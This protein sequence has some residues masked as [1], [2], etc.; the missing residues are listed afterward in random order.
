MTRNRYVLWVTAF[1][2]FQN[3]DRQKAAPKERWEEIH[4]VLNR[5]WQE[6]P[7]E[8]KPRELAADAGATGKKL[9][10]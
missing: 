10:Q 8:T 5:L 3:T 7:A 4:D 1:E 6:E 9:I 2:W